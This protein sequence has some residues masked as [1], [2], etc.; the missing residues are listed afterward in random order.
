MSDSSHHFQVLG[1]QE[2]LLNEDL[3]VFF[4]LNTLITHMK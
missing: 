2:G 3:I 4:P 1:S